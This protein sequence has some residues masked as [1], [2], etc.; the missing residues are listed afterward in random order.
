MATLIMISQFEIETHGTEI[1]GTN[2]ILVRMTPSSVLI[3][4][5]EKYKIE[6]EDSTRVIIEGITIFLR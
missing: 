1:R 2:P 6:L 3:F 4:T 5:R